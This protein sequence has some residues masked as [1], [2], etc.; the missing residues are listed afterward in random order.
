MALELGV[1]AAFI[2]FPLATFFAIKPLSMLGDAGRIIYFGLASV[3]FVMLMATAL[4]F[5][6]HNDLVWTQ[7]KPV[8]ISTTSNAT[9]TGNTTITT[10]TTTYEDKPVQTVIINAYHYEIGWLFVIAAAITA[11]LNWRIITA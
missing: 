11:A 10:E 6:A 3:G 8:P 5:F 7:N 9:T 2:V 4:F 1:F